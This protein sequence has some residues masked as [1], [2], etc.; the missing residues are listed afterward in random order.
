[1]RV[2]PLN[3][4][5]ALMVAGLLSFGLASADANAIKGTL[6]VGSFLLLGSTLGTALGM[7][8]FNQRAG[9]NLRVVSSIFF[10]IGLLL[11][12]V[13]C[14]GQFSQ[15]SYVVVNGIVFLGF[16]LAGSSVASAPQ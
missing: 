7:E 4:L 14:F 13:F 8:C 12:L 1:M 3:L 11:Q 9:V 2:H 10:A 6:A 5:I 16:V 15:T